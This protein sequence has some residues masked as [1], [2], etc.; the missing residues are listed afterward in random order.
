MYLEFIGKGAGGSFSF[1]PL[2]PSVVGAKSWLVLGGAFSDLGRGWEAGVGVGGGRGLE[3]YWQQGSTLPMLIQMVIN[4]E[5]W[6][7]IIA[8]TKNNNTSSQQ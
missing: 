1:S 3:D 8:S 5:I 7:I 2:D 4:K 6:I